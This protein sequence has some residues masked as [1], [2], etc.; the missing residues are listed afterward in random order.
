MRTK[1]GEGGG[2]WGDGGMCGWGDGGGWYMASRLGK[3][4]E[5]KK[6][7]PSVSPALNTD[8]QDDDVLLT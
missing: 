3:G 7:L 4:K 2:A 6:N 8:L 1:T 5:K